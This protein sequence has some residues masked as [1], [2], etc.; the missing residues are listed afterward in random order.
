VDQTVER[1]ERGRADH[2]SLAPQRHA[3]FGI[4]ILMLWASAIEKGFGSPSWMTLKQ[5]LELKANVRKG[6][7]GSQVVYAN[8]IT[9]TERNDAGEDM[10]CAIHF[11]KGYTVFDC[12]QIEG[13]PAH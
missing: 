3:L 13:L 2:A 5:A 8:S 11:L 10:D 7:K 4:N 12:D 9:K 1:R 6:E